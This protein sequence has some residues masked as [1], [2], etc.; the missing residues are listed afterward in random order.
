MRRAMMN[1]RPG[2]KRNDL[3]SSVQYDVAAEPRIFC[4]LFLSGFNRLVAESIYTEGLEN[5]G[6]EPVGVRL[7]NLRES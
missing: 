2:I 4:W 6:G 3:N 7:L 5:N 1:S